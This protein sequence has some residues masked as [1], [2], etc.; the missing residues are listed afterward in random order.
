MQSLKPGA[1][2][3]IG[4]QYTLAVY[5]P[6]LKRKQVVSVHQGHKKLGWLYLIQLFTLKKKPNIYFSPALDRR[7]RKEG[8]C[9][10]FRKAIKGPYALRCAPSPSQQPSS[11]VARPGAGIRG[12]TGRMWGGICTRTVPSIMLTTEASWFIYFEII[13]V[14]FLKGKI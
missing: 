2:H 12:A 14:L 9:N 1:W 6:W 5:S 8:F 13:N 4:V 7:A 11:N 10:P 3:P